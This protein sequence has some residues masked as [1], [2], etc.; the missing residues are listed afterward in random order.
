VAAELPSVFV[1][2]HFHWDREWYRTMQAFRARLVDAI[3]Q[4]LE[5]ADADDDYRFLL[6]GQTIVLEDYLVVR[7]QRR[8]DLARHIGA[9]RL[10]IGPW[11]VQPDSLLPSAESHIRN[12]LEGRR[13]GTAFGPVSTTAYVPDSFGHPAQFPLLFDGFGLS[14]F[15]HWRG[16]G[17]ELDETGPRWRWRGPDGTTLPVFHLTEGYF[18]ASRPPEDATAAVTALAELVARQGRAGEVP[19]IIMNG[20]DHTRPDRHIAALLSPLAAA[21]GT[22]VRHA[23]LDDAV[24]G[25]DDDGWPTHSGELVGGRVANLLPGVWSTRTPLKIRNRRC[26]RL[27]EHWAEP[28]AA[29]GS[30]LGLVDE[31]PSLREAWRKLVRN[32]AHDSICGCSI[33]AVHDRMEAR[34]D[35]AEGLAS[36]T[37]DRLLHRLAGRGPD[38]ELDATDEATVTVFNPSPHPVTALVRVPLDP[39][40]ALAMHVGQ[41]EIHPMVLAGLDDIGFTVEGQ[42]VRVIASDDPARVRWLPGQRA[43][44]IE[45]VATDL[46]A[47]GCRRFRLRRA[48]VVVDEQDDGREITA[49]GQRVVVADD[50]TVT[51]EIGGHTWSGLFGIEDTGDRGDSYDFDPVGVGSMPEPSAVVVTRH[52]HPGGVQRLV[53]ERT[54][55]LPARLDDGRE[56]RSTEGVDLAVRLEV[57]LAAGVPGVRVDVST[58]NTAEDHRL[59]LRFPTGQTTARFRA[60]TTFDHAARSTDPVDDIN[61]V[62]RA[63]TTFCQH[64]QIDVNGL[65]V[66]A[67]DLAE[68]E[69]R[70][71]GDL[72]LTLV[73]SVGW[74]SRMDLASRP[75]PAGP[76]MPAAGA[77]CLETIATTVWLM[78]DASPAESRA[79]VAGARGVVG[80]PNPMI[81]A[82]RPLISVEGPGLVLSTLKPAEDG[83]GLIIRLLNPTDAASTAVVD[84]GVAFEKAESARLDEETDT[85]LAEVEGTRVSATMPPRGV[86]TLRVS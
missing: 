65:S 85:G 23:T 22:D 61:W 28:W 43:Q 53:V 26:E 4:V 5:L 86:R 32:Q 33:D 36:E 8:G 47:C 38:R 81:E 66:I 72:L 45:F 31:S 52:R 58:V 40:P 17:D 54:F 7:P 11:Y 35:D 16:N 20:F 50:G 21:L 15:V 80:G 37:I 83:Q 78:A 62:H 51:A 46:P 57:V 44:D 84:L 13:T 12:L 10:A 30:A 67:P 9:G 59:R 2:S 60:A 55:P 29:L 49:D 77:Q 79:L 82:E 68:A 19:V 64:G 69:V 27:L 14:A 71:D 56:R 41:P 75:V 63:P 76:V 24:A 42:P 6:D 74:L 39:H 25:P 3:D 18:G 48:D 1:I 34:F 70:S 73:R